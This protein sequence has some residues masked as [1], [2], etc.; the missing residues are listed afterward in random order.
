MHV[1]TSSGKREF[2]G[3]GEL[4]KRGLLS[5]LKVI[6]IIICDADVAIKKV[7]HI[8]ILI[9]LCYAAIAYLCI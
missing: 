3:E 8:I 2:T 4:V 5:P 9:L 7:F 1:C 6:T